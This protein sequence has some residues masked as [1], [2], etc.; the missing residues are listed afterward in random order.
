MFDINI[1]F[2]PFFELF[3]RKGVCVAEPPDCALT[4]TM[5]IQTNPLKLV[6][7]TYVHYLLKIS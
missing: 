3:F 5:L 6:I 1:F 2:Y 4:E 7:L